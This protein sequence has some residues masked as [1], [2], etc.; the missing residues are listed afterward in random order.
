M[1]DKFALCYL[2]EGTPKPFH[3]CVRYDTNGKPMD[4]DDLKKTIFEDGCKNIADSHSHLSLSKVGISRF[5]FFSSDA[6]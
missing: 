2:V 4:V 5:H 6:P 3:I 1:T